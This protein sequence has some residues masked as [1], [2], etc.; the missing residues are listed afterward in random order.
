[1]E[2]NHMSDTP[3]ELPEKRVYGVPHVVTVTVVGR[4]YEFFVGRVGL[5]ILFGL[6]LYWML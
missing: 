2:R 6:V 3:E 1:M 4:S 5:A